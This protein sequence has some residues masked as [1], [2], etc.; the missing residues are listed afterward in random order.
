M[1]YTYIQLTCMWQT[2]LYMQASALQSFSHSFVVL[3]IVAQAWE[4]YNC[5]LCLGLYQT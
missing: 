5:S 3:R 2:N 4:Y 1:Y